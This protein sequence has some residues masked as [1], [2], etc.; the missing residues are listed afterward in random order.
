MANKVEIARK[1]L[2]AKFDAM[3]QTFERD[4]YAGRRDAEAGIY[5]KWYRYH[6]QDEGTAYDAGW[7]DVH[8]TEAERS[9]EIQVIEG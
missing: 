5:D 2:E 9:R 8:F 7:M 4:V 3:R 1:Q 6:R